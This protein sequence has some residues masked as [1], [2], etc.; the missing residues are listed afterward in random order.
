MGRS[1]DADEKR[2]GVSVGCDDTAKGSINTGSPLQEETHYVSRG[3]G[4]HA[5]HGAKRDDERDGET[6]SVLVSG[7]PSRLKRQVA[8]YGSV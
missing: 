2:D 8:M 5:L 7:G 6:E 3:Q 4:S 1:W